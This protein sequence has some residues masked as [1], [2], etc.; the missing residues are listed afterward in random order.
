L[1]AAGT[2]GLGA[3]GD[4]RLHGRAENF[5]RPVDVAAGDSERRH[6]F[7]DLALWATGLHQ[8]AALEC[9]TPALR[10][11]AGLPFT[12]SAPRVMPWNA[13]LK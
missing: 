13:L 5:Q 10:R 9:D 1:L 6:E 2:S 3:L 7:H 4:S 11:I 8:Q 12:D